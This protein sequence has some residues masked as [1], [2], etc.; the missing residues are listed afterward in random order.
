LEA[1]F[2]HSRGQYVSPF[3]RLPRPHNRFQ[4]L[5]LVQFGVGLIDD[6]KAVAQDNP[7]RFQPKLFAQECDGV[8]SICDVKQL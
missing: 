5:L 8:V 3:D 7:G 1:I 6:R 4:C 2:P